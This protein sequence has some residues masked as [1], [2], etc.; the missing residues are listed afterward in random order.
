M[1]RA[2]DNHTYADHKNPA[3]WNARKFLISDLCGEREPAH[4]PLAVLPSKN[5]AYHDSKGQLKNPDKYS[6]PPWKSIPSRKV[7]DDSK[8][9]LLTA[10]RPRHG[11][12]MG[13]SWKARMR[14]DLARVNSSQ[15]FSEPG[16]PNTKP[17]AL[18]PTQLKVAESALKDPQHGENMISSANGAAEAFGLGHLL[19]KQSIGAPAESFRPEYCNDQFRNYE[20]TVRTNAQESARL[21]L[22]VQAADIVEEQY[23]GAGGDDGFYRVNDDERV[24][25]AVRS[26]AALRDEDAAKN[27]EEL[28]TEID[29]EDLTTIMS[30]RG[31]VVNNI[32]YNKPKTTHFGDREDDLD[33]PTDN[34]MDT[35]TEVRSFTRRHMSKSRSSRKGLGL[36]DVHHSPTSDASVSAMTESERPVG[37][38]KSTQQQ[39]SSKKPRMK[40][41]AE[42]RTILQAS[43]DKNQRRWTDAEIRTIAAN[44]G[45]A[46]VHVMVCIWQFLSP[47]ALCL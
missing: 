11:V 36:D 27:V 29:N 6:L 44:L 42:Q 31:R 41:D 5:F 8:D 22:L 13:E 25:A 32:D 38:K 7:S 26:L 40:W 17:R 37:L 43:F 30:L 39:S 33:E 34:L 35:P 19:T 14:E 10:G 15:V 2:I 18:N 47:R 28:I 24:Q 20:E 46:D 9:E 1:T 12:G 23:M 16:F 4:D 3:T 45:V 21:K